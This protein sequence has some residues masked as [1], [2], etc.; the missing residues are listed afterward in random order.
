M[1][2]TTPL[3]LSSHKV[4]LKIPFSAGKQVRFKP[5]L[6]ECLLYRVCTLLVRKL[7]KEASGRLVASKIRPTPHI[8]SESLSLLASDAFSTAVGIV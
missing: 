6:L 5:F 7:V 4:T 2:T 8:R 3:Y 1:I